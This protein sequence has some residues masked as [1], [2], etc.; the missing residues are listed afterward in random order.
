MRALV[1][2]EGT[3]SGGNVVISSVIAVL[4]V[5]ALSSGALAQQTLKQQLQGAWNLVSCDSKQ[6]FCV[7]PSGSIGYSGSG[8]YI[9]VLT[10]K[11]RPKVA[12]NGGDRGKV[13]PEEY[14]LIAQGVVANFGTYSVDEASKTITTRSEGAL[15]PNAIGN[16][17]KSTI[18]NLDGDE[19]KTSSSTLGNLTW[20]RSK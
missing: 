8:R 11:D 13:T 20:R 18:V 1:L 10:A 9:M 14:K 3:M 6:P 12:P 5:T 17:I 16:E 4:G 15:F 7:N 19:L 2:E